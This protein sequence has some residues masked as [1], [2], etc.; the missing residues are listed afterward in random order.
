MSKPKLTDKELLNQMHY[1]DIFYLISWAKQEKKEIKFKHLKY[2]LVENHGNEKL[3]EK[4]IKKMKKFFDSKEYPNLLEDLSGKKIS[5]ANN[6]NMTYLINLQ[7]AGLIKN[8]D[9]YYIP[10]C[11]GLVISNKNLCH[12]RIDTLFEASIKRF[13]GKYTAGVVKDSFAILDDIW[14]LK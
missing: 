9:G 11:K 6:L 3:S 4:K 2:A 7:N 5:T 10:T 13:K 14:P 1:K 12:Q 8:I